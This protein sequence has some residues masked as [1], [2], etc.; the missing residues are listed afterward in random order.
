MEAA[1]KIDQD[2]EAKVAT[3]I[4][5]KDEAQKTP[6]ELFKFSTWIHVGA[7][8][9]NCDDVDE[10]AGTCECTNRLHFHG[11]CRL[12]NQ[13]QH[14][15]IRDKGLA[16]K[17]RRGRQLRD[18][19]ADSYQI[20]E[21]ELDRLA[22]RG[23]DAKDELI[24]ELLGKEWW[25]DTLEAAQDLREVEDGDDKPWEHI[26]RDQVR[27]NELRELPEDKRPKDEFEELN[28][29]TAA[30]E[31]AL[32]EQ[33]KERSKPRR[34]ALEALDINALIDK[35]RDDRI[36]QGSQDEFL[37]VYQTWE[38]LVGTLTQVGGE[39][40]FKSLD[41]MRSAAPEV[42]TELREVF[43]DLDR[44]NAQEIQGNL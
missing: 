23:D 41:E 13:F 33:I 28:R 37:H 3:P 32:D 11:W 18:P 14:R 36:E 2:P 1:T 19:E 22:R 20:L 44:S 40:R 16:A 43:Q 12:P 42:L 15:E 8:A 21:D 6:A 30:Y 9:E 27:L 34:E 4:A 39:P 10:E 7:G 31:A 35:V 25:K 5:S 17:A 24:E 38:W 29:H 26:E